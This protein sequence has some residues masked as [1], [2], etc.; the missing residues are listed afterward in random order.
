M[1]TIELKAREKIGNKAKRVVDEGYIPAV[2][3]DSKTNSTNLKVE[4]GAAER[5]LHT[6]QTTSIVKATVEGKE[7]QVLVKDVDYHPTNGM[8]RHIAFFEVDPNEVMTFELPVRLSG[9]S[10]AVKNNLGI[11]IQPTQSITV[12]AK[13]DK[14][15]DDIEVKVDQLTQPGQSITL[16]SITLPEG[17]ELIHK[18]QMDVALATVAQLQKLVETEEADD[19]SLLDEEVDAEETDGSPSETESDTPAE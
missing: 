16:E 13:V 5:L 4:R 9:E 6:V 8:I 3:Y 10:P 2:V 18:D 19:T 11:L 17:I 1:M 7:K 15:V 14:L 12:R